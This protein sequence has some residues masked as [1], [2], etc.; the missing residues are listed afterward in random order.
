M[1]YSKPKIHNCKSPQEAIALANDEYIEI[2]Q[3]D[4]LME[5]Q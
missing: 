3:P 4:D 1:V 5:N 2:Y